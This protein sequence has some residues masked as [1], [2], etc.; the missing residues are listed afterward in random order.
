MQNLVLA[1]V[2]KN[3]LKLFEDELTQQS[4]TSAYLELGLLNIL[5][6]P[7]SHEACGLSM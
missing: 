2:H 6:A 1:A 5:I 3:F 7:L 4:A